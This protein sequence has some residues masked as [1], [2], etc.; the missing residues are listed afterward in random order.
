M[1]AWNRVAQNA[2][3]FGLLLSDD[4]TAVHVSSDKDEMD[5]LMKTWAKKVEK[6]AK[7]AGLA[8]PRLS[9]IYSPYRRIYQPILDSVKK[10]REDKPDRIVAVI[11]PELVEPHWYEYLMHNMRDTGLK[12]LLFLQRE[13][14]TVVISV[15]WYLRE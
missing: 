8:I 4:V 2:V 10:A 6:P 11:I 5:E 15:P 13:K 3:R 7:T 1:D 9:L 14:R 12:A